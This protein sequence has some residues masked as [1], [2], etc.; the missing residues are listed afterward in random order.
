MWEEMA[1][2]LGRK[3]KTEMGGVTL[4]PVSLGRYS[5]ISYFR[6]WRKHSEWD[7]NTCTSTVANLHGVDLKH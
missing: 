4:I 3:P 7:L 5:T 1:Q 2:S 6:E